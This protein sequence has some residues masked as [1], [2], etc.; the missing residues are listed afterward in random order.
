MSAVVS[1][2]LSEM[3]C[4]FLC[5]VSLLSNTLKKSFRGLYIDG[6]WTRNIFLLYSCP[7][8]TTLVY[9]HHWNVCIMYLPL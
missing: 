9:I 1:I 5:C 8:I 3:R 4:W 7:V 2:W 6:L